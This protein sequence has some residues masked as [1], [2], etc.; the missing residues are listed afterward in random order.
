MS[1]CKVLHK[2][3]ELLDA[4]SDFQQQLGLLATHG[5]GGGNR[6]SSSSGSSSSSSASALSG[7]RQRVYDVS[8][9]NSCCSPCLTK[10]AQLRPVVSRLLLLE[11][12]AIKF[13]S[14]AS[15]AY[16]IFLARRVDKKLLCRSLDDAM[17]SAAA[18][19]TDIGDDC[20]FT[21][22]SERIFMRYG[23]IADFLS[24]VSAKFERGMY[25][26]PEDN[27]LVPALFRK[28]K[29]SCFAHALASSIDTD[30][31]EVVDAV[32]PQDM[33]GYQEALLTSDEE[34]VAAEPSPYN[35]DED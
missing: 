9:L 26:L 3:A 28:P 30:G 11:V 17:N 21:V 29:L 23:A 10:L 4:L 12:N 16:L 33:I 35:S 32:S 8:S 27:Q 34:S 14:K 31:I 22:P 19:V 5:E 18:G 25:K 2:L 20:I 6:S 13:Y 7:L 1:R 15:S 24:R